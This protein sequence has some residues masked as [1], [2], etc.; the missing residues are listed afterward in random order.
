[1][2]PRFASTL[3][4]TLAIASCALPSVS[5]QFQNV[6]ALFGTWSS[7]S[8]NVTTGLEFFNPI[9]QKFILPATAGISYSFDDDGHFEQS[10]Y[11]FTS[12]AVTN[13]CF[14]ASLIWQHGNYTLNANG[15]ITLFP[16]PADGYIQVLDPC[17]AQTSAIYHYSEFELIPSWYNYQDNH[18]GFMPTGTSAYALQ[19]SRFDGAK[20]PLMWL[21]TSP[22][23]M[24]PTKELFQQPLNAVKAES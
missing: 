20:M 14:K 17:G 21:K 22:P 7:G 23:N 6:T 15:S 10:K 1:M 19:L 11:Q 16:F 24:L 8:Q 5:A 2:L 12:N 18:P 9:N 4:A 3:C 13:R